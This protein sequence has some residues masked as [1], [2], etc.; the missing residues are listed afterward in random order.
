MKSKRK[1]EDIT[2]FCVGCRFKS[3]DDSGTVYCGFCMKKIMI[4]LGYWKQD[5]KQ[6][7]T[8]DELIGG[9]DNGSESKD[10]CTEQTA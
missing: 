6:D 9:K 2:E 5:S 1:I 10:S 3:Y 8:E 7:N 4:D